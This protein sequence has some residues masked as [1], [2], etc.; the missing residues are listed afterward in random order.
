L[1]PA[2]LGDIRYAEVQFLVTAGHELIDTLM[3]RFRHA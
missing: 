1:I 3:L 2:S